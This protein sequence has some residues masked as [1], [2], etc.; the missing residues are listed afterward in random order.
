MISDGQAHPG[1]RAGIANLLSGGV[2][3]ITPAT[4]LPAVT[5]TD[6]SIDGT[7]QTANVG[8]TNAVVLGTGG[9]VGVDSLAL[10]TVA[11]PEVEIG[12]SNSG[13]SSCGLLIQAANAVVRSL[14]IR[15]FGDV[16]GE[17]G[18]CRRAERTHRGNVLRI[19]RD[20]VRDPG[21]PPRSAIRPASTALAA[22]STVQQPDQVRPRHG[23]YLAPERRADD[24]GNE[25]RDNGLDSADGDGDTINAPAATNTSV[26]N[27]ITD[28]STQGH[29]RD[30]SGRDR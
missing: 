18:V 26:A 23:V 16:I 10:N 13:I 30:R 19:E 17:A 21:A 28:S 3:V 4:D 2:A 27:L 22:A 7:T 24:A 1:L 14:A 20:V 5:A 15:G 8:N 6:T 12:G 9:T 25:V 29:R 11:G